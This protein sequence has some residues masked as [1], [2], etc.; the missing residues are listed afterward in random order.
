M[1]ACTL[2]VCSIFLF[3]FFFYKEEEID[4]QEEEDMH[5]CVCE[6]VR[7]RSKFEAIYLRRIFNFSR[8]LMYIYTY[9]FM[10][11]D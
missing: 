4:E 5:V 11:C 8:T 1:N 2:V 9:K 10:C 7:F 6:F 3:I